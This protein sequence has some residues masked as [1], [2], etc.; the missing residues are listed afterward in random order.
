MA[1]MNMRKAETNI[2]PP[3]APWVIPQDDVLPRMKHLFDTDSMLERF[4]LWLRDSSE[5]VVSCG[6]DYVRYKPHTNCIVGYKLDCVSA[7]GHSSEIHCYAKAL[8]N[9]EYQSASLKSASKKWVVTDDTPGVLLAPEYDAIL[10]RF[11]NDALLGGLRALNSPKRIQRVLY[12]QLSDF[13]EEEWRISDRKLRVEVVSYKPERRAVLRIRTKATHRQSG[14]RRALTLYARFY[15][16]ERGAQL[17]QQLQKLRSEHKQAGKLLTPEPICYLPESRAMFLKEIEGQPLDAIAGNDE[18]LEYLKLTAE[19][20]AALHKSSGAGFPD[21]SQGEFIRDMKQSFLETASYLK[22]IVPEAVT[23][24]DR[25]CKRLTDAATTNVNELGLIHGDFHPG[26]VICQPGQVGLIDFDRAQFGPPLS[27][28][29]N[30]IAHI[31]WHSVRETTFDSS[32]MEKTLVSAYETTSGATIDR[33]ELAFWVAC[34]M[35][36]L[37]IIPFRKHDSR[38]REV[39]LELLNQCDKELAQ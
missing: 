31:R 34:R 4:S 33:D 29:A 15:T 26:Q 20:L 22:A 5:A 37:A 3:N 30:F 27:D 16:D 28:L 21:I 35:F 6:V 13:P 32:V 38:W 11:P 14:D 18:S 24:I 19:A 23:Q 17:Y 36:F 7:D 9:S 1:A 12:L 10:Y 8:N 25:L 39:L 2:G